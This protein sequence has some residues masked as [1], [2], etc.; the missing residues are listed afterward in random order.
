MKRLSILMYHGLY[1]NEAQRLAIDPIDRPYAVS[2]EAFARQLDLMLAAKIPVIHPR[3]VERAGEATPTGV[4]LTFDDGHAS[5]AELA[6]PLLRQR[7]R[8]K[9]HARRRHHRITRAAAPN[10]GLLSRVGCGWLADGIGR[11]ECGYAHQQ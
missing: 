4:L 7:D 8:T 3:A 1:A 2:A 10:S 5:N 9:L 6:L 11:T